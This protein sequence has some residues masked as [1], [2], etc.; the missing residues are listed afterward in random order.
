M[1]KE[2]TEL[3]KAFLEHLFSDAC[4][5]NPAKA[6]RAAGYSENTATAEVVKGLKDEIVEATRNYLATNSA[7]A[8]FGLVDLLD[9]P[10]KLGGATM[11]SAAKEVLDRVGVIKPEKVTIDTSGGVLLL[12]PKEE[13]K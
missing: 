3:Q 11:L 7:K 13:S 2:L 5:G 10:A 1:A 4:K 9:N 12:P 8:A 6:K